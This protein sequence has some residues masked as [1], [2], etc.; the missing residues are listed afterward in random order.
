MEIPSTAEATLFLVAPAER[1]QIVGQ[2]VVATA[3]L[4]LLAVFSKDQ[5]HPAELVLPI[6]VTVATI[7][8]DS[9]ARVGE[10]FSGESFIAS[11]PAAVVV[12]E[13]WKEIHSSTGSQDP[14]IA[15]ELKSPSEV[16]AVTTTELQSY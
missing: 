3:E 13:K 7:S 10:R 6:Q 15:L 4:A 5:E 11:V 14:A 12:T 16:Q 8:Q 2:V 1:D 9:V